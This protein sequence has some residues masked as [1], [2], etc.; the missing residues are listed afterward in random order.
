VEDEKVFTV[1]TIEDDQDT[2][3]LL[4][5]L[6][7]RQGY[8]VQAV[9]TGTKGIAAAQ[10]SA[11]DLVLL[12]I[13]LPDVSGFDVCLQIKKEHPLLPV[14]I[15]SVRDSALDTVTGL[16]IGADD[17][18][19]KP[20]VTPVLLARVRSALHNSL[21]RNAK[22]RLDSASSPQGT[23]HQDQASAL[24]DSTSS[25]QVSDTLRSMA[26]PLIRLLQP[27]AI[28]D[29][30]LLQ[31]GAVLDVPHRAICI[32]K[33]ENAQ[34]IREHCSSSRQTAKL[35][36]NL[37]AEWDQALYRTLKKR[38]EPILTTDPTSAPAAVRTLHAM[39]DTCV[40][41]VAPVMSQDKLLGALL[42]LRGPGEN[43]SPHE[44]DVTRGIASQAGIL[45][46]YAQFLYQL[47]H[48]Q[49]MDVAQ[50]WQGSELLST[51]SHELR[52]PLAAIKGFITTLL[53]HHR[54]WDER[55]R[56][57]FLENVDDSVNQLS[58]LVE[59]VLEM[60]RLDKGLQPQKRP[61]KLAALAQRVLRDLSF[62][63]ALCELVNEIPEDLP[64]VF[65]DPI[66]IERVL[67]NLLENAIKFSPHGGRVRVFATQLPEKIEIGVEDQGLGISPQHLPHIFERFYQAD[68]RKKGIG[69]GLYI[70]QELVHSHGGEIRAESQPGQGTTLYFT[71]PLNGALHN[72]GSNLA[73][74]PE[75]V[76]GQH[77]PSNG[78]AKILIVEDDLQMCRS[79]EKSLQAQGFHVLVAYHGEQALQIIQ[80]EQPDMVLLDIVLPGID[81]FMTCQQIRMFSDVPVIMIT[82]KKVDSASSPQAESLQVRGLAL[83]ADDYVTK[84]FSNQELLA[85]IQALLRRA[86]TSVTPKSAKLRFN[87]FE[88][89]PNRHEIKTAQGSIKLTPTEHKLLYYFASNAGQILTHEQLLTKVWG[90][91]CDQQT[92]YLWVNISRLRKKIEPDPSH[93]RYILT[94]TGVGYRFRKP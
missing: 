24:M 25:P 38:Q 4:S 41:L 23:Q 12:D 86:Q 2:S 21:I 82:E 68:P 43:F 67:H 84:P 72:G 69:L 75:L 8:H 20:F 6:L 77:A 28:I 71:L 32:W 62:Q 50:Q 40:T 81:G 1:L 55:E 57:A 17:Y 92:D 10:D 13:M 51:I 60:G 91:Q 64:I 29:T 46:D 73:H 14:I 83:G 44:L 63:S 78:S 48:H 35:F 37:D 58:R 30:I 19:T 33:R 47:E 53:S 85:R 87:G 45:L 5:T 74:H 34:F 79:L 61:A 66:K 56:E 27:Q 52:T 7:L 65:F 22:A 16:D 26:Q 31:M 76:S 88:I 42:L 11:I 18:I 80:D 90:D 15:L 59:N 3:D 39:L 94:E 36:H 93:P 49:G 89:A 70:A 54:Y 9:G